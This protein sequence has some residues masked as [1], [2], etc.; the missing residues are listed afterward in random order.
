MKYMLRTVPGRALPFLLVA[1]ALA[2]ILL[3]T[4]LKFSETYAQTDSSDGLAA[5]SLIAEAGEGQ[6]TLSWNEVADA[7]SYELI[8]W[9]WDKG[10]WV[11]IG[12]T[13]RGTSCIRTA[14]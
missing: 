14:T 1:A 13:L 5:P 9:D 10:E 7:D 3:L 2:V 4:F 6:I 12:G 11:Q 8:F